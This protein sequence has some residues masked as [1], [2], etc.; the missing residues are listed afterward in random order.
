MVVLSRHSTKSNPRLSR[1]AQGNL[2]T[3][4]LREGLLKRSVTRIHR[5][6]QTQPFR[7]ASDSREDELLDGVTY[8]KGKTET[9]RAGYPVVSETT[10]TPWWE[11]IGKHSTRYARCSSVAPRVH[12]VP[13]RKS[14]ANDLL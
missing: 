1:E 14:P 8:W 7:I 13:R 2:Q 4:I 5:R 9:E 10:R 3:V 12:R 11:F 6:A